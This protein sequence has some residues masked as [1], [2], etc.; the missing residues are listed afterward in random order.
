M[1]VLF[2]IKNLK[3]LNLRLKSKL[4]KEYL[5]KYDQRRIVLTFCCQIF[6]L[7]KSRSNLTLF[8]TLLVYSLRFVSENEK[9]GLTPVYCQL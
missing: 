4:N 3:G 9:Q 2:L 6:V 5:D 7:F 8:T 1:F